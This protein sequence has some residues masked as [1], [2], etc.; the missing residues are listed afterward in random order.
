MSFMVQ[1]RAAGRAMRCAGR[2]TANARCSFRRNLHEYLVMVNDSN[3]I[4]D[5]GPQVTAT[6]AGEVLSKDSSNPKSI[7]ACRAASIEAVKDA[8][9][10]KGNHDMS[11]V[12]IF[13]LETVHTSVLD[14]SSP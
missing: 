12:K 11:T 5:L 7:F 2:Y 3:N 9:S 10:E 4:K 14:E 1:H 13:P 8:L 6:F